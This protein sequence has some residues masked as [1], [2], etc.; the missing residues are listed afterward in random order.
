MKPNW[1]QRKSIN[2]VISVCGIKRRNDLK[3]DVHSTFVALFVRIRSIYGEQKDLYIFTIN[4]TKRITI[5]FI[6]TSYYIKNEF[7][8]ENETKVETT[9]A[10]K[11]GIKLFFAIALTGTGCETFLRR[12]E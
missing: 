4:Y 2:A 1:K 8:H 12:A 5:Q 11:I 7:Y 6:S 3:N 9:K 10:D